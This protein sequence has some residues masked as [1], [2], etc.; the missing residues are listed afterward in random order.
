MRAR[1]NRDRTP[2]ASSAA[3]AVDLRLR[4]EPQAG[5]AGE[6]F[7]VCVGVEDR[8][9][10]EERVD[11]H[12]PIVGRR[13]RRGHGRRGVSPPSSRQADLTPRRVP[14]VR[15]SRPPGACRRTSAPSRA[16]SPRGARRRRPP[17]AARSRRSRPGRARA[18]GR[19]RPA[20]PR[21]RRAGVS[22]GGSRNT[23][24]K[25]ASAASRRGTTRRSCVG[26]VRRRAKPTD[27]EV[28]E[29]RPLRGAVV[30][31]EHGVRRAARQRLDRERAAAGV[32]VEHARVVDAMAAQRREQRLLQPV[33]GR[34]RASLRRDQAPAADRS[35]DHAQRHGPTLR[36]YGPR[37]RKPVG[38]GHH[39]RHSAWTERAECAPFARRASWH[40][41]SSARSRSWPCRRLRA[42]PRRVAV[43]PG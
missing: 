8:G 14:T 12:D 28:R 2:G 3:N 43:E 7:V 25:G 39:G 4:S 29:D 40:P 11:R 27:V 15:R 24:S 16:A 42:R 35:R 32:E 38:F 34:P 5:L 37:R 21:P 13:G 17:S 23:R 30:V 31:D 20:P 22:Y 6:Q 19:A 1:R 41:R 33:G 9:G 10:L 36:G 26:P 18:A